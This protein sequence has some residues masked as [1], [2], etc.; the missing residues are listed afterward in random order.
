MVLKTP[1]ST[2]RVF[3]NRLPYESLFLNN[4]FTEANLKMM[5]SSIALLILVFFT[6]CTFETGISPTESIV[7]KNSKR[8]FGFTGTWIA[9]EENDYAKPGRPSFEINI[10]GEDK[11]LI[12][13]T[14]EDGFQSGE[15]TL[16]ARAHEISDKSR[17]ALVEVDLKNGKELVARRLALAEVKGD[18]LYLW[19]LDRKKIANILYDNEVPAV[20]EHNSFSSVVRCKPRKL[21]KVLAENY[22]QL[23]SICEVFQRKKNPVTER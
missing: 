6:G 12:T 15:I 11:Y 8:D 22:D 16:D 14:V 18:R 13:V 10:K 17:C 21:R 23:K 7:N 2:F 1:S 9:P 4:F 3:A 5:R 19:S 20:I